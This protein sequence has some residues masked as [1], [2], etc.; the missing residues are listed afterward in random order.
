MLC[1]TVH[2]NASSPYDVLIAGGLLGK[3]GSLIK[4]ALDPL[5]RQVGIVCDENVGALFFDKVSSALNSNGIKAFRID[6]PCGEYAKRLSV[7][8]RIYD[9]LASHSV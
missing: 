9:A 6:V 1:S 3:I 7:I 4:S 8:E 5:P 2:V